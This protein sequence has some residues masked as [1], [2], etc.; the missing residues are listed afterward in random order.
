M[1]GRE[2]RTCNE[3]GLMNGGGDKR[4]KRGKKQGMEKREKKL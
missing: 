1:I 4:K 3:K 2:S